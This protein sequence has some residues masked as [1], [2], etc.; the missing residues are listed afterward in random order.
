[1]LTGYVGSELELEA[2]QRLAEVFFIPAVHLGADSGGMGLAP[3]V[4]EEEEESM[5]FP[6]NT[7]ILCCSFVLFLHRK[8]TY[9]PKKQHAN[10]C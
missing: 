4:V 6:S 5:I 2:L 10:S 3:Q 1:M 7:N 8:Q 9:H